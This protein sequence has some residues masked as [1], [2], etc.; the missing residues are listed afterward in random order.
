MATTIKRLLAFPLII[1]T[2]VGC[3]T[4][5]ENIEI[6][7]NKFDIY[8]HT[9]YNYEQKLTATFNSLCFHKSKLIALAYQVSGYRDNDSNLVYTILTHRND[10]L[11]VATY[12]KDKVYGYSYQS[13]RYFKCI[14]NGIVALNTKGLPDFEITKKTARKHKMK[15]KN[16]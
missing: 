7:N 14:K 15:L 2:C 16:K 9:E 11:I 13:L 3:Y 6:C 1:M 12:Y 8:K 10:S 5:L 4:S